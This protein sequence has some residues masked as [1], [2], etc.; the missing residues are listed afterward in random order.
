MAVVIVPHL[1]LRRF[2]FPNGYGFY[3]DNMVLVGCF[4]EYVDDERLGE[5]NKQ[6]AGGTRLWLAPGW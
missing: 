4:D 3:F 2:D 1:L 6:C 5:W